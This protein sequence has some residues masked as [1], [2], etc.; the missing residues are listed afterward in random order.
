MPAIAASAAAALSVRPYGVKVCITL[1]MQQ[2][3]PTCTSGKIKVRS[4]CAR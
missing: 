3:R 4:H 1:A 2:S